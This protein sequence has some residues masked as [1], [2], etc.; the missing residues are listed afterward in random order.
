MFAGTR[1]DSSG[2]TRSFEIPRS[3][4]KL[5]FLIELT[6]RVSGNKINLRTCAKLISF[7]NVAVMDKHVLENYIL[8]DPVGTKGVGEFVFDADIALQVAQ[9]FRYG[10]SQKELMLFNAIDRPPGLFI[11]LD[12]NAASQVCL[13]MS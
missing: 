3:T 5:P 12:N 7:K 10:A 4:G 13:N 8:K 6:D 2:Y 11:L 1:Q 9:V